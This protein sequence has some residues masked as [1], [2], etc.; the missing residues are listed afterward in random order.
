M[1]VTKASSEQ[2]KLVIIKVPGII[3]IASVWKEE[4][5]WRHV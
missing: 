5:M 3:G 2:D 4:K 1:F